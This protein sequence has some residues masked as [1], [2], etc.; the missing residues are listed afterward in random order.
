[1]ILTRSSII[2]YLEE[3]T[4]APIASI[5]RQIPTEVLLGPRDG[6]ARDC[7]INLDHIQTVSKEKLG[8][9]ITTLPLTRMP[10]LKQAL[11]FA[12][13]LDTL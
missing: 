7:L 8:S 11:L 3:V 5:I 13:A 10:E 6:M 9:L 2:D 4:I 12:F 1:M